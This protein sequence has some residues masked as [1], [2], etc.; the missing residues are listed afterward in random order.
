MIFIW[1]ISRSVMMGH[2]SSER[3]INGLPFWSVGA[4]INVHNYDFLKRKRVD[5]PVPDKGKRGT[6]R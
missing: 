6:D 1:P 3:K 4:G 5:Q 2:P